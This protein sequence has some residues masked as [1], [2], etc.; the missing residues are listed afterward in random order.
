MRTLS[1]L[2]WVVTE[3]K[4]IL[5]ILIDEEQQWLESSVNILHFQSTMLKNKNYEAG[6]MNTYV[7]YCSTSIQ[8]PTKASLQT[9]NK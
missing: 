9:S 1:S 7:T 4:N 6:K 2:G 3:L 8:I 5:F